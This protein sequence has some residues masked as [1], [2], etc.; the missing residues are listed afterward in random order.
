MRRRT[1][2]AVLVVTV[3]TT[4]C[5]S[6]APDPN[7]D[8]S[9]QVRLAFTGAFSVGAIGT[10]GDCGLFGATNEETGFRFSVPGGLYPGVDGFSAT[11][12]DAGDL[13]LTLTT[14]TGSF[15]ASGIAGAVSDDHRKMTIDADMVGE[16]GTVHIEGSVTCP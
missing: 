13:T 5:F 1:R 10:A 16:A 7:N 11:E 4:G 15:S 6:M 12:D 2:L 8:P 14:A 3:V 9:P